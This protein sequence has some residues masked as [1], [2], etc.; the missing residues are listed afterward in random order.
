[1]PTSKQG[2]NPSIT[3]GLSVWYFDR[4]LSILILMHSKTINGNTRVY[5]SPIHFE[6]TGYSL[7]YDFPSLVNANVPA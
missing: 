4:S 5:S 3:D 6:N 1:M 2:T 7:R